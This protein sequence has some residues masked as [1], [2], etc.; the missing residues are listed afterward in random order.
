M[1]VTILGRAE[2]EIAMEIG[3]PQK[4][5]TITPLEEPLGRPTPVPERI[6][7]PV[8]EPVPVR[9]PEKVPA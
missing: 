1:Q 6:V 7:E 9:V 5:T 2:E 4:T 3:H 8:R